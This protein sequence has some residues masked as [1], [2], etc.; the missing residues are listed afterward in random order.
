MLAAWE[1]GEAVTH[2]DLPGLGRAALVAAADARVAR[3]SAGARR[4][5][6]SPSSGRWRRGSCSPTSSGC[7]RTALVRR[8]L[9]RALS[10]TRRA[11]S[12][13]SAS[14]L[15]VEPP[16]TIPQP[17]RPPTSRRTPRGDRAAAL[18]RDRGARRPSARRSS[19]TARA[20]SWSPSRAGAEPSPPP[21]S[22]TRRDLA[23]AQRQQR[24]P[25]RDPRPARQLAAGHDLPDGQAG[26]RPQA[27]ATASTPTSATSRARW[28]STSAAGASRS[29]PRSQIFEYHNV[30]SLLPKI[31]AAAASTT[32]ASSRAAPT[33]PATSASTRSPSPAASS[34]SSRPASPAWRRSTP[35]T[36][37]CP[38]GGRR[39][40]S[41]LAAEDRC[42]LNGLCVVDDQV[43]YVT[44]LGTSDEAGGWRENKARGGRPDRRADATRSSLAGLSMPHSPRWY[45]DKLWVLESGEGTHRLRR[46][47][48]RQGR[49]GRRA[50]RLH[51]RPRLR[52]PLAFVGLSQV[53][54]S[55]TFGGLPLTGA[56]RGAPVRRLGGRHRD[57]A[58]R[59]RF[60]RFEDL[61][62]EIFAVA[63]LPGIALP[64]DRR[65]GLRRGQPD[66]R[67]PGRGAEGNVG[68]HSTSARSSQGVRGKRLGRRRGARI[69]PRG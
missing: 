42:H 20:A 25:R 7:R 51:P 60:L 50:A 38:A 26:L 64:R 14:S 57:R 56:P 49:D 27:T 40:S 3:R 65:A 69:L 11:S 9:H 10:R 35:S 55:A 2:P 36:A 12:S 54:E 29:G 34:G 46:P 59:S 68:T 66:V 53:R 43:R 22:R 21:R 17:E 67:A 19:P 18:E 32:P 61:V 33:S 37:S 62:Q 39:S 8:R 52:R 47:R 23:A 58:R 41:K 4:P 45:R 1:S 24:E 63:L 13:G 6:S 15:D 5:R 16:A 30:P 28:G 48:H 31:A 44:A